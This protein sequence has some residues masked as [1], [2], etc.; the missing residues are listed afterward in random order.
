MKKQW[1]ALMAFSLTMLFMFGTGCSSSPK[2]FAESIQPGLPSDEAENTTGIPAAPEQSSA[3]SYRLVFPSGSVF[4]CAESYSSLEA[5]IHLSKDGVEN[6]WV[7]YDKSLIPFSDYLL[8][9][10][11]ASLL[12]LIGVHQGLLES[13]EISLNDGWICYMYHGEMDH[14]TGTRDPGGRGTEY[15]AMVGRPGDEYVFCLFWKN[16]FDTPFDEPLESFQENDPGYVSLDDMKSF[17]SGIV[18]EEES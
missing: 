1:A 5:P 9:H 8:E 3:A 13:W 4:S 14:A 10:P 15:S 12:M 16:Y 7:C 17:L 6:G 11:D 2:D 18:V